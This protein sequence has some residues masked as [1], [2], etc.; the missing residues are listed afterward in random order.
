ME[1][2]TSTLGYKLLSGQLK[3]NRKHSEQLNKFLA[4]FIDSDG[5]F[6][7]YFSK[8]RK[9]F[10]RAY[11]FTTLTQSWAN[12]KDHTLLKSLA[13]FYLLGKVSTYKRDGISV[14]D[15]RLSSKDTKS[16]TNRIAKHLRIKGTHLDNLLWLQQELQGV[17]LTLSQ[18]EELKEFSKCS[19]ENSKW[20]KTPKHPS[21]SWLAGLLAGDGHFR[22]RINR[23][24]WDKRYSRY[25]YHNQLVVSITT[26]HADEFILHFIQRALGGRI[27]TPGKKKYPRWTKG[28]G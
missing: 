11:C 16:L 24:V 14:G 7:L 9:G 27:A 8:D 25:T 19:R 20:V 13:D 2:N 17:A 18:V 10:Y 3:N 28:L 6:F 23:K 21:W 15:W 1:F 5:S 12:D 4:G 22:C 26:S